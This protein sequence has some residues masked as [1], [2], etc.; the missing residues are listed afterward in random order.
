ML[1]NYNCLIYT[2]DRLRRIL[3]NYNCLIYT[4]DRFHR[5][6]LKYNC[7]IY[8]TDRLRRLTIKKAEMFTVVC[9]MKYYSELYYNSAKVYL[10]IFVTK[11]L[12]GGF[13]NRMFSHRQKRDISV[14]ERML[15]T[16]KKKTKLSLY[17][18]KFRWDRV[19]SH[20]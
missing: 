5:I 13:K 12:K 6:R 15:Y 14:P 20:K 9:C 1:L 7:L 10:Q 2:I 16:D 17:I 4:I 19:Q 18:S 8:T 3:L 11:E